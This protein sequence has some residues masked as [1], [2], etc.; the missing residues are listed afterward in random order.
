[1][2]TLISTLFSLIGMILSGLLFVANKLRLVPAVIYFLSIITVLNPWASKNE[3]LAWIIFIVLIVMSLISWIA[4][5]VKK[6]LE[7]KSDYEYE[8]HFTDDLKWQ[9]AKV[10][11]LGYQNHELSIDAQGNIII[12][13]TGKPIVY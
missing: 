4:T 10:R 13:S 2:V 8:K 5:G 6:L 1:M 11:E 3:H 12:K 9:I 7:L